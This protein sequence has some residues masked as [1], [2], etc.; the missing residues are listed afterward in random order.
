MVDLARSWSRAWRGIGAA[1][2]G[3]ATC[4]ALRAA[5]AEPHRHYHTT[6]HL[7]ECLAMFEEAAGLAESP[8]AVELA[9]WF[10]DAI[11]AP[12]RS[13][14]EGRSAE[15]ARRELECSGV[16]PRAA[17]HVHDLVLAT[18]HDALPRT[19]DEKVLVDIDLSILGADELRFAEYERQVR[20]EYAFVP[21]WLFRR[22]RRAILQAFLERDC[23]YNM[24]YF[25]D[26]LEARAR[27]N[28]QRA[29]GEQA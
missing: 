19:L 11:H 7:A 18:R 4:S 23:I 29:W 28:L 20:E 8:H 16:D 3:A 6:Q 14:N 2:T 15:L 27:A 26:R 10:H 24:P 17:R 12:M 13:D 22:K 21:G 1:D 5:Y 9:I 25:I